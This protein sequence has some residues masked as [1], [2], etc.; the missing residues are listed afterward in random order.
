MKTIYKFSWYIIV[1]VLLL[2]RCG[3]SYNGN[4]VVIETDKNYENPIEISSGGGMKIIFLHHSTGDRI[5]QGGVPQWFE[6]YNVENNTNYQ[7][8]EQVFPKKSPYGWNNY[9]YD[10]WNIWVNHAGADSFMEEP[11]LEILTREYDVIIWKHCFPVSNIQEYS[12]NL[13]INSQIKSIENYKLHYNALKKK[14]HEFPNVKFIVWTGAGLVQNTSLKSKIKSILEGKWL[15]DDNVKRARSFFN[16]VKSE[17]NEPGDNIY[18]WDFYELET[19]GNLYL[20]KEYAASPID[21]HPNIAFSRMAASYFVKRIV[22]VI[23][24]KGD[25]SNIT[26]K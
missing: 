9:P 24:G 4:E 12:G 7:I 20:K 19:E 15:N 16:W 10:Y 6:R 18:I 17:W 2:I 5:W 23:K 26:G 13:D 25:K 11:T 1:L 22:N 3:N 21:S 8:V 14:M